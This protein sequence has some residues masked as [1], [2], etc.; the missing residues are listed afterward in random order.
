MRPSLSDDAIK[1]ILTRARTIA[2]VGAVDK[3]SR[4]VDGVTR[5]LMGAGYEIIPVHPA[6]R[7]VW[8]L[9]THPSLLDVPAPID[10][11][12]LFRAPEHCPDHAREC[13]ELAEAGRAPGCFWMQS[14]IE[15]ARAEAILEPTSTAVVHNACIMLMHKRLAG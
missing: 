11:V 3:P 6:R 14:G 10:I 13:L 5:Y 15:S 9:T 1:D 8:G 12:N 7:G 4:P 2:V